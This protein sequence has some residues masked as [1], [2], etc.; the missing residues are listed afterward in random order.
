MD[1]SVVKQEIQKGLKLYKAFE[2]GEQVLSVL[3]GLD[4]NKKEL[5]ASVAKL[6]AEA[7]T[8]KGDVDGAHRA[9][10]EAREEAKLLKSR[11]QE[12]AIGIVSKAKVEAAVIV[13]LASNEADAI[14][15]QS[16]K[17]ESE[18]KEATAELKEIEAKAK[19]AND[20]IEKQKAALAKL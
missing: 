15:T 20:I 14:R 9:I 13:N 4:A 17:I 2:S 11:A 10:A 19:K 5:T 6:Q 12:E 18:I 3:E 1:I 7:A 8:L 16:Y